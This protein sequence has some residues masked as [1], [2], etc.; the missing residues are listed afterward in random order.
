M[1]S[2]AMLVGVRAVHSP[3]MHELGACCPASGDASGSESDCSTQKKTVTSSCGHAHH[4]HSHEAD[5]SGPESPTVPAGHD[6][7]DECQLCQFLMQALATISLPVMLTGEERVTERPVS[8]TRLVT[9]FL[10]P[11]P[12]V[13]GPPASC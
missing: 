8:E 10:L 13:R 1:A 12:Y 9:A 3:L 7:S 6:H 11:G 2:I 5:P 4:S